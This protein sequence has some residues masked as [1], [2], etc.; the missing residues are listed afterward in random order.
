MLK[1]RPKQKDSTQVQLN[2]D[3]GIWERF[4]K[5]CKEK[6][7]SRSNEIDRLMREQLNIHEEPQENQQPTINGIKITGRKTTTSITM[8]IGLIEA[9]DKY[10]E[11]KGTP[12]GRA[13][14]DFV[15]NSL[16]P[17]IT[18][19]IRKCPYEG[20]NEKVP[21]NLLPKHLREVHGM[22]WGDSLKLAT[23]TRLF[24]LEKSRS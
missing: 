6:G 4:S 7:I 3:R 19:Q 18:P 8:E 5:R 10:C 14:E 20:C 22:K 17:F 2:L 13:I 12:R 11:Q 16:H 9:L 1:I 21:S 15:K 23:D 24:C